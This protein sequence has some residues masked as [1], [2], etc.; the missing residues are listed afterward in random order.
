MQILSI[1][2]HNGTCSEERKMMWVRGMEWQN[3]HL[4]RVRGPLETQ[5]IP[6]FNR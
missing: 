5:P 4:D 3:C 1:T 2:S 6:S